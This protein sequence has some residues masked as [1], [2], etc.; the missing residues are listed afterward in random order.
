MSPRASPPDAALILVYSQANNAVTTGVEVP[1][2]RTVDSLQDFNTNGITIAGGPLTVTGN[3][4]AAPDTVGLFL[5]G[6]SAGT[7]GGR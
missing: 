1:A 7:A 2:S 4:G 3:A 6:T 5:G